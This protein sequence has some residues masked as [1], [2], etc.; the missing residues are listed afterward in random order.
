MAS[1]RAQARPFADQAKAFYWQTPQGVITNWY[2]SAHTAI[3]EDRLTGNALRAARVYALM[4]VAHYDSMVACWDGK[5]AYWA[6]RPFQLDSGLTTL[7]ATP[8]HPSYPAAHATNSTGISDLLAYL[9]PS[10]EASFRSQGIEAGW[11]RMVA[12]IHYPSDIDA[13]SALGHKVAQAV[14]DWASSDG[15][16][17]R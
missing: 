4:S 12:G 16:A 1:L 3:F 5:Y 7:F 8:N 14:I 11:S 13:G 9:F 17:A 10:R 15:S 6:I 2:D